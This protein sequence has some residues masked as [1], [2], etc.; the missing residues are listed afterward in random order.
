MAAY[1]IVD[2]EVT[3]PTTYEEYRVLVPPLVAKY[4]GKY[5]VR[6]GNFEK[7]EGDWTP[8]RLV[9]LE[10]ESLERAKE[11]YNSEEY[12]PVKQIRLKS[13]K[14]NMVMVEGA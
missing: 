7:V 2:I 10:F 4:G 1:V 5:L 3:D 11:F 14:S 6:G 13:T 8:T 12:E 9:V